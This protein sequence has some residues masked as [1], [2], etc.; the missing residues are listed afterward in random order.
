MTYDNVL[1]WLFAVLNADT[2]LVALVGGTKNIGRYDDELPSVT[3]VYV[4]VPE[5]TR[6]ERFA[7]T[8]DVTVNIYSSEGESECAA[9][10]DHVATLLDQEPGDPKSWTPMPG[11]YGFNLY[12]LKTQSVTTPE[13]DGEPD[14]GYSATLKLAVRCSSA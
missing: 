13:R 10:L 3:G 1:Q 9:L 6:D 4:N 14:N 12:W 11:T 5:Q 7:C 8:V 2:A